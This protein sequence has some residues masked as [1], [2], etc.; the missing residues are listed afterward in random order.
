L[1]SGGVIVSA[2]KQPS[3]RHLYV[4]T[5][6]V[7]VSVI[8]TVFLVSA[9]E[10][11]SRVAVIEGEVRVQQGA[12]EKRLR[13]G[14]ELATNP[15]MESLPVKEEIAW[16]RHAEAHF[17]LL[18]QTVPLGPA[19]PRATF[20]VASIRPRGSSGGGG[21]GLGTSAPPAC[22]GSPPQIDPGRFAVTNVTLYRLITMAYGKACGVA[23]LVTEVDLIGGG[24]DWIRSEKFDV[25]AT[26]PEGAPAYSRQQLSDGKAPKLQEMLQ[27][28]LADRFKLTLRRDTKNATVYLLTVAPRGPKLTTSTENE[29]PGAGL[30][31]G[32][33]PNSG[34]V[35]TRITGRKASM[36]ALAQQL[37]I[38]TVRP[39]LDRTGITGEFTYNFEFA[40]LDGG[41]GVAD[42]RASGRWPFLS[43]PSLFEAIE[44]QLG[45]KL[46]AGRAPVEVLV[47]D[48]AERP[49]EN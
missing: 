5:K 27:S 24:P 38:V 39:V 28:L 40:P 17:A 3:G 35:G 45:L 4:R 18:Q 46:E 33:N 9:E 43:S 1:K 30:S 11:G 44:E 14:D 49:T 21:R 41:P 2:A 7:T 15:K 13:S 32:L 47:V 37:G 26:M 6:D 22:G 12:A 16:S 48:H 29:A 25:E 23:E 8:G 10:Q 31:T 34:I 20:A 42:M 19:E 36:S